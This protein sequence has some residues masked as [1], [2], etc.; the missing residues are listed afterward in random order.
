FGVGNSAPSWTN[1]G[2]FGK[3]LSF[4][5]SNDFINIPGFSSSSGVYT[6]SAWIKSTQFTGDRDLLFD[7]NGNL[8]IAW[9]T[10]T[11]GKIGWYDSG[12]GSWQSVADTPTDGKWHNIIWIFSGSTGKVYIDGI[13]AGV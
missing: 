6:M 3:A 11:S 9:Q 8:Q 13:Y 4:D 5:G 10:N 7:F 1:D 12:V 2:K